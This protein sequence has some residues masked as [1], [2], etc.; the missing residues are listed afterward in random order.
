[1]NYSGPASAFLCNRICQLTRCGTKHERHNIIETF[2]SAVTYFFYTP[3]PSS[4]SS[5]FSLCYKWPV[6]QFPSK[7][8]AAPNHITSSYIIHKIECQT[9]SAIHRAP[10]D[11]Q[12][13]KKEDERE[14]QHEDSSAEDKKCGIHF[15]HFQYDSTTLFTRLA[16]RCMQ[17]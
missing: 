16:P 1:M 4:S 9:V 15:E 8:L 17:A 6:D 14:R 3:L 11:S 7:Q 10:D 2:R 12:K 5:F 13:A